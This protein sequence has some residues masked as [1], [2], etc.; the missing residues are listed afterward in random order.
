V[1]AEGVPTLPGVNRALHLHPVFNTLDI[2]G[3]GRPTRIANL[4]EGIDVRQPRGSLPI[5][6]GIQYRTFSIPWFKR[7]RPDAI[8]QYAAAFRKVVEGYEALL[9]DDGGDP[10]DLGSWGLTRGKGAGRLRK[11]E[12]DHGISG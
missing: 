11:Q 7:C 2:Y 4:P 8:A 1:R 12:G 6:E 5:A 9:E 3:Q 10:D